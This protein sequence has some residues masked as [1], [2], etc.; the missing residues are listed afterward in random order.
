[1]GPRFRPVDSKLDTAK[2]CSDRRVDADR[3]RL[4]A[5]FGRAKTFSHSLDPQETFATPLPNALIHTT[6]DRGNPRSVHG[7]IHRPV[8]AHHQ[9]EFAIWS[10]EPIGLLVRSTG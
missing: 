9:D 1:R 3:P 6:S 8:Q 5:V 4:R 10:G 7:F 2:I